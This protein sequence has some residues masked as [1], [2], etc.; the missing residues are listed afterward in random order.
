MPE[1]LIV[2]WKPL[3]ILTSIGISFLGMYS[4]VILYEQ[5]RMCSKENKP[6]LL[7]PNVLLILMAFSFGAVGIWSMHF[8]GMS[9]A[10]LFFNGDVEVGIRYRVD[11]TI[12]SLVVVVLLC[13]IGLLIASYD[14]IF[15]T[16][17]SGVMEKFMKDARDLSIKEIQRLRKKKRVIIVSLCS[18]FFYILCGGLITSAGVCVMHYLGRLKIRIFS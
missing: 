4:G 12:V 7:S 3:N 9:S 14:K 6:K 10:G 13:Y 15:S 11:F 5:F 1:I 8:I 17:L 16:E 18:G 2:I